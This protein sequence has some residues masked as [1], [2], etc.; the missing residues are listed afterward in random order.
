MPKGKKRTAAPQLKDNGEEH[1]QVKKHATRSRKGAVNHQSEGKGLRNTTPLLHYS[2]FNPDDRHET[3]MEIEDIEPA[4]LPKKQGMV[5][6]PLF[7]AHRL[8]YT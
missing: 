7:T 8:M 3:P 2:R 4:P 5:E 6:R 1:L